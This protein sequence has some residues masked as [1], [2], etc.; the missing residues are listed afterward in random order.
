MT[1]NPL[2]A[3]ILSPIGSPRLPSQ[4]G[5]RHAESA[6]ISAIS[7]EGGS[8]NEK[9]LEKGVQESNALR[10]TVI[11]KESAE[12]AVLDKAAQIVTNRYNADMAILKQAMSP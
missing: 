10:S 7:A 12:K 8:T 6:R 11:N 9:A 1:H 5:D 4:K 3:I 2:C